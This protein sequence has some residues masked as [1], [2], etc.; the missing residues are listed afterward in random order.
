[1][2]EKSKSLIP[3]SQKEEEIGKQIVN[4]AF[5]VHSQLETGLL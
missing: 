5:K 2:L 3:L 4:S 1:M